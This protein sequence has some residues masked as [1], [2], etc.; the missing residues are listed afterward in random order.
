MGQ[1][2]CIKPL[3]EVFKIGGIALGQREGG[4]DRF[5]EGIGGVEGSGEEGRDGAKGFEMKMEGMAVMADR[6]GNGSLEEVSV[7]FSAA[8]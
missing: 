4:G 5:A 1:G 6:Y 7:V 3:S 2:A 8:F